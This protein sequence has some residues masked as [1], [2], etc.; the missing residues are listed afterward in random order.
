MPFGYF[1]INNTG[2]G[3]DEKNKVFFIYKKSERKKEVVK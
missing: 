3:I 2:I 1:L